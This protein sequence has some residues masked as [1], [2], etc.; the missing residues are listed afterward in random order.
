MI[1]ILTGTRD[2]SEII[3]KKGLQFMCLMIFSDKKGI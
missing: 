3:Y 1:V 2:N